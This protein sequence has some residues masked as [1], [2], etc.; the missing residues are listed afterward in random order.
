MSP[1]DTVTVCPVVQDITWK[2]NGTNFVRLRVTFRRQSRYIKTN[3]L[4]HKSQ[5]AK[6][7]IKDPEI[8]CKVEDLLNYGITGYP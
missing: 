7:R 6:D 3:I 1:K 2:Q 4:V 5:M 8:R